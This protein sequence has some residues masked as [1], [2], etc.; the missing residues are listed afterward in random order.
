MSFEYVSE[1]EGRSREGLRMVV[2]GQVPSGWGEAA[3][4]I[5]HIKRIDWAAVRLSYHS[6][7]LKQ[8]LGGRLSGPVAFWAKE[9]PR[10]GW[11]DILMLAERLAPEPAL[12]PTDAEER[13]VALGLAHEFCGEQGLGWARRV[14]LVH[15]AL[16]QRG[17]F[18]ERVALY[19][20]RKYGYSPQ[21]GTKAEARVIE[22]LGMFAGRLKAQRA[23]GIPYYLRHGLSA[24]DIYSATFMAMFAPLPAELCAMDPATRQAFETLSVGTQAALDPVLLEHRDYMYERHLELPLRL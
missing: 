21:A 1:E 10:A 12:L 7:S 3:K 13:C 5:L 18:Q 2:V 20:G 6:D 16:H 15:A 24:V 23:L 8:W 11:A 9:P 17:G 4:G 22:L 14:Q 19:L